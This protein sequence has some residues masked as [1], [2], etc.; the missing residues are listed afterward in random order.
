[1][2]EYLLKQPLRYWWLTALLIVVNVGLFAWQV[3]NGVS[4]TDPSILHLIDW[5]ADFAPLTLTSEN[6]RLLSSMFLHIGIMHLLLNMW[7]LYLFGV[8]AE[9]YYGRVWYVVL[10]VIA[11]IAGNLASNYI[12][13]QKAFAFIQNPSRDLIP[14][15]GAGASGAIMGLG[16]ALLV[17]A[18]W[19]KKDLRPIY[20]LNKNALVI[21]MLLNLGL[22]LFVSGIN[23]A[24]HLGGFI[25]GALLALGF[26]LS[27][28]FATSVKY[29]LQ[30]T[31]IATACAGVFYLDY[32]LI[33]QA[34][35]VMEFWSMY[36]I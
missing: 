30:F 9:F 24:A 6:W 29:S 31:L 32:W 35:Q 11:G 34:Q 18:L 10:Y 19:P 7:A 36:L 27:L 28:L 25:A 21:L 20:H 14:S 13:L 33:M 15:V 5:G 3:L 17:A 22:G 1:M 12:S 23:S 16:G 26:H 4:V 2:N 8:Y